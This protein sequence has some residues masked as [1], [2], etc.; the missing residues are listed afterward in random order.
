MLI[1]SMLYLRNRKEKTN[2]KVEVMKMKIDG[3]GAYLKLKW[4]TFQSFLCS[5]SA[6]LFINGVTEWLHNCR[7]L[8]LYLPEPIQDSF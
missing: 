2:I 6:K 8:L 3:Q 7:G 1:L 4:A 5:L